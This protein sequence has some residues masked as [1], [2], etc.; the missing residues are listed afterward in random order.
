MTIPGTSEGLPIIGSD[1]FYSYLVTNS[2]DQTKASFLMMDNSNG[3]IVFQEDA[4]PTNT[5]AGRPMAYAPLGV[6]RTPTR[7]N[8]N[9]GGGNTNDVLVWGEL[10]V[11]QR[12]KEDSNG[13]ALFEGD[14]HFFQLPMGFDFKN[15]S[16]SVKD[17]STMSSH[18]RNKTTLSA[19]LVPSH[20]ALLE[21]YLFFMFIV[22]LVL[23]F[24]F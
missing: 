21:N 7:G 11:D 10:Y 4:S 6:G 22:I 2:H 15:S 19:P 8:W 16:S 18:G 9:Q 1:G 20:G 17:L 24:Y 14:V 12:W 3:S 5:T 23:T 13:V